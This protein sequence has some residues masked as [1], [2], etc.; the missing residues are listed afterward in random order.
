MTNKS[1]WNYEEAVA[2]IEAIATRIESGALPLEAVFD[3]FEV[4]VKQLRQ[5][6]TFLN[7][8]KERMDLLIETLDDE[9]DF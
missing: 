5:C 7:R 1:E 3:Q 8:G 2:E 6:E 4:A 9:P